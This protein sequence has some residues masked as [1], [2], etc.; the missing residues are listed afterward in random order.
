ML[1]AL[2]RLLLPFKIDVST[3]LYMF[4]NSR[5]WNP[6]DICIQTTSEAVTI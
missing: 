1:V 3:L 4:L 5:K 6:D 2:L